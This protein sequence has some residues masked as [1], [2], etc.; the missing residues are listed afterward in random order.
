M[1]WWQTDGG[2]I[3]DPPADVLDRVKRKVRTSR[4]IPK[5]T[6]SEIHACYREAFDRNATQGEL[7]ALI[8]FCKGSSRG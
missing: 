7:W 6:L 5:R 8:A 1:G 4:E 2:A 3:G